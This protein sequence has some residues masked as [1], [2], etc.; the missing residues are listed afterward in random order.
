MIFALLFVGLM[1][2]V[3]AAAA[4]VKPSTSV[5]TQTVRA[6]LFGKRIPGR[7]TR[8]LGPL[9]HGGMRDV[10]GLLNS[11]EDA[12]VAHNICRGILVSDVIDRLIVQSVPGEFIITENGLL[13]RGT[14]R[15]NLIFIAARS[16]LRGPGDTAL[17]HECAKRVLE[18]ARLEWDEAVTVAVRDSNLPFLTPAIQE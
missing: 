8:W 3:F 4:I 12:L 6:A 1:L 7:G 15:H 2:G 14:S 16:P 10:A 11:F 13:V 9:P 18:A 5:L 17:L